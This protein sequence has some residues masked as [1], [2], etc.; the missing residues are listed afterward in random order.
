MPIPLQN[1]I[2]IVTDFLNR[3]G[4]MDIDGAGEYLADDAR[5]VY[6]YLDYLDDLEGRAAIVSQIRSTI[7]H[8]FERMDFTFDEWYEI[9]DPDAVI[10]EYRSHCPRLGNKGVYQNVYIGVFR[11]RNDKIT[12]YKEYLNPLRLNF[13]D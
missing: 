11:F 2:D 10:V 6:P 3:I 13:D 5:T 8:M 9:A 7:P 12:L 4:K 1:K